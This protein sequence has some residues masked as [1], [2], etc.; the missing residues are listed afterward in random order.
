VSALWTII[1]AVFAA[2]YRLVRRCSGENPDG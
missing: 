2:V 1:N